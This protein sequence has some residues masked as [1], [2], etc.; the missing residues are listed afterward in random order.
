M[1]T[2]YMSES[3]QSTARSHEAEIDR[4]Q[5]THETLKRE[6]TNLNLATSVLLFQD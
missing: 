1:E 2:D 4:R 5:T 6:K 3:Q